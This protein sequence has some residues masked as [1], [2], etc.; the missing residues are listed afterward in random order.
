MVKELSSAQELPRADFLPMAWSQGPDTGL[1]RTQR[2][3]LQSKTWSMRCE[4]RGNNVETLDSSNQ[5]LASFIAS[6]PAA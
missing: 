2:A 4:E 5:L 3:I 1:R 6:I